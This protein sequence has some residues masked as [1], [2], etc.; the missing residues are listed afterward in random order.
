MQHF[1]KQRKLRRTL[2]RKKEKRLSAHTVDHATIGM[3]LGT[4][5]ILQILILPTVTKP[6]LITTK[7]LPLTVYKYF[8]AF[9][10]FKC[11]LHPSKKG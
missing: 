2:K 9:S 8:L 6:S 3:K 1:S 7:L 11:P 5:K 4:K 10:N